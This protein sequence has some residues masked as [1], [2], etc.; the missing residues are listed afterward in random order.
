MDYRYIK[1]LTGLG[2][3]VPRAVCRFSNSLSHEQEKLLRDILEEVNPEWQ[4]ACEDDNVTAGECMALVGLME[5]IELV[6]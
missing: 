2:G 4:A 5:F 3:D 1:H 6:L